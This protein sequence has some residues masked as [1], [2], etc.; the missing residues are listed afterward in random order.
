MA[1]CGWTPGGVPEWNQEAVG[2]L[3]VVFLNGIKT[4]GIVKLLV[5]FAVTCCTMFFAD[6]EGQAVRQRVR[7]ERRAERRTKVSS[8]VVS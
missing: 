2:G 7:E 4:A 6:A 8:H 3:Q 1:G 5:S